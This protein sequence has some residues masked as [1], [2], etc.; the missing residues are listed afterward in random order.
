MAGTAWL[1]TTPRSSPRCRGPAI[2][3]L[4]AEGALSFGALLAELVSTPLRGRAVPPHGPIPGRV[5]GT[6]HGANRRAVSLS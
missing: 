4:L 6:G 3:E 2:T 5:L 1:A